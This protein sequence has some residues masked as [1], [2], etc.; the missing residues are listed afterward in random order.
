MKQKEKCDFVITNF[1]K[2]LRDIVTQHTR[3]TLGLRGNATY[4]EALI[5]KDLRL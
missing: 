5:R 3:N 2:E 4:L 1:N